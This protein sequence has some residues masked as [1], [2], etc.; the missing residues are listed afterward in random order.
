MA[1]NVKW[2][3]VS[4]LRH[5]NI[6]SICN[7]ES[8]ALSFSPAICFAM[9][10]VEVYYQIHF[11]VMYH[12]LLLRRKK[13]KLALQMV[14]KLCF[15]IRLTTEAFAS[16]GKSPTEVT[17]LPK[18][19]VWI[20]SSMNEKACY[21]PHIERTT[22][23]PLASPQFPRLLQRKDCLSKFFYFLYF[24]CYWICSKYAWEKKKEKKSK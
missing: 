16:L 13:W 1:S 12:L 2:N 18:Q 9:E 7:N 20:E 19:R 4:N 11:A 14:S 8:S 21:L 24:F 5:P 3:L 17:V 22:S 10:N 15:I 23:H 6:I